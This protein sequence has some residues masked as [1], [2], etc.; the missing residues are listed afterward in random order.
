[1]NED[2]LFGYMPKTNDDD[3]E[4]LILL[5]LSVLQEYYDKYSSKAPEYVIENIEKD[6]DNLKNELLDLFYE[7]FNEYEDNIVETNL[8]EYLIPIT[9]KNILD[10][11]ISVTE[12]IFRETIDSLIS[13]LKLD[14]KIKALVWI[15]TNKPFTE[16]DLNSHFKKARLKLRNA[17]VYYTQTV[18]EKIRRSLLD[19]VYEEATYD[20]VCAG[21]RPCAWCIEQSKMPP[22]KLKDMPYDHVNGYCEIVVHDGKYSKEYLKIRG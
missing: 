11:D 16:F 10:Y 21:S 8:N 7:H 2:D 17:G 13:Q 18:S 5:L 14:A 20:W 19:F 12:K 22:R 3:S 4:V 1:M 9:H 6:I 15:D